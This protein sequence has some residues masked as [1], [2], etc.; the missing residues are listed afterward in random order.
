[1]IVSVAVAVAVVHV[2]RVC[3]RGGVAVRVRGGH[4]VASWLWPCMAVVHGRR[5]CGMAS[6][7]SV[8]WMRS[9]P[10]PIMP[11]PWLQ[12]VALA[13]VAASLFCVAVIWLRHADER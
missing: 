13:V 1:M 12:A 10:W 5:D 4:V 6:W 8:P 3:G 7:P 9:Q 2:R 11:W